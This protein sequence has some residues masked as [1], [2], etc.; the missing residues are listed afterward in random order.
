MRRSVSSRFTAM[1]ATGL[2]AVVFAIM[3]IPLAAQ[4]ATEFHPQHGFGPGYDKAHEIT[5]NGSIQK[6]VAKGPQGT[7]GGLHLLVVASQ[8]SFD[9][10][11]GP[12]L[13]KGVQAELQSGAEVRIVGA[14]EKIR[15]KSYLL[16]RE[17]TV[18]GRT[19]VVRN[20]NGFLLPQD[21]RALPLK[22]GKAPR[23]FGNGGAQ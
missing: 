4:P 17:V 20:E 23:A 5:I 6:V 22:N 14:I 21:P 11:L 13:T 7:P 2:T 12:Y 10:H 18:G 9:T 16:A 3:T 15:G 19:I 8:G 1:I